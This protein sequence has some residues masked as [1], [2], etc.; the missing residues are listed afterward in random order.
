MTEKL[1]KQKLDLIKNHKKKIEKYIGDYE[2]LANMF[3]N[4]SAMQVSTEVLV[5]TCRVSLLPFD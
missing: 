1:E 3:T 5:G 2:Y 4:G